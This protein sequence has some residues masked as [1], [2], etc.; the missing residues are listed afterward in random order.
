MAVLVLESALPV[1]ELNKLVNMLQNKMTSLGNSGW[2]EITRTHNA[3]ILTTERAHLKSDV[4]KKTPSCISTTHSWDFGRVGL[5]LIL[6]ISP[7]LV[8]TQGHLTLILKCLHIFSSQSCTNA[9]SNSL[10]HL[11]TITGTGLIHLIH[12]SPASSSNGENSI[13][14]QKLDPT[15]ISN[16]NVYTEKKSMHGPLQKDTQCHEEKSKRIIAQQAI[17]SLK[18]LTKESSCDD[19]K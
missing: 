1:A 16:S 12:D 6:I 8:C 3:S 9:H 14:S 2:P 7:S 11:V 13:S 4:S 17:N 19:H 18:E 15:K 10:Q 5:L